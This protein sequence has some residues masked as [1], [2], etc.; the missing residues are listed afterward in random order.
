MFD[1]KNPFDNDG[2]PKPA[3]T[4]SLDTVLRVQRPLVLAMVK[5]LREKHPNDTPAQLAARLESQYLRDVTVGGGAIGASAFVPGIGTA[6]SVGL[7][8]LAVGGYLERTAIFAQSIAELHGVPLENPEAARTVVMGIMLGE[9]GA[10][11][12]NTL[13]A[14]SS[15]ASGITNKWALMTGKQQESGKIFSV[16]RT[17]RNMFVKRFLT[18]QS[19]AL[20]GRALPFGIGAVVGGGANLALGRK[21]VESA[22]EAFGELPVTFP[23]SLSL[24]PRAPKFQDKRPASSDAG[25]NH[26]TNGVIEGE[27]KE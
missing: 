5:N 20:L 25:M 10:G 27:I 4:K 7:S 15:K 13:M 6:T 16:E 18:R 3:L 1:F 11:L 23:E 24:T 21:V 14:Q 17:I 22:K 19:G 26:D 2:N 12:M 9:D 8:A